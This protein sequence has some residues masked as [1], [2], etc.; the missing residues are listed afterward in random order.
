MEDLDDTNPNQLNATA[1]PYNFT[2]REPRYGKRNGSNNNSVFNESGSFDTLL[3]KKHS[4]LPQQTNLM[5]NELDGHHTEIL[6]KVNENQLVLDDVDD[7]FQKADETDEF[8]VSTKDSS[9]QEVLMGS[10]TRI[11]IKRCTIAGR[12]IYSKVRVVKDYLYRHM[13][14]IAENN[15]TLQNLSDM[16]NDLKKL[17]W[18]PNSE[19]GDSAFLRWMQHENDEF[20]PLR[21]FRNSNGDWIVLENLKDSNGKLLGSSIQHIQTGFEWIQ[22]NALTAFKH[23]DELLDTILSGSKARVDDEQLEFKFLADKDFIKQ[24]SFEDK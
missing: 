21:R 6:P 12:F 7:L 11:I 3:P 4:H 16:I 15:K 24:R 8:D 14:K 1:R 13:R 18:L 5:N 10:A 20:A 9:I 17:K 22:I 23:V 19:Y 2:N